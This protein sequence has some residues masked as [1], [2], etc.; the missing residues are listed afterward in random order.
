MF[1]SGTFKA[2]FGSDRVGAL[3]DAARAE[4]VMTISLNGRIATA[5]RRFSSSASGEAA[6]FAGGSGC[7]VAVID[8]EGRIVSD[9]PSFRSLFL[10]GN[11][12]RSL[13]DVFLPEERSRIDDALKSSQVDSIEVRARRRSDGDIGTFELTFDRRANGRISVLM[14]DRTQHVEELA[15]LRRE[16]ARARAE[17]REGVRALGDL[18]HEM[19]TPLNAVIGFADAMTQETFGPLGHEKYEEYAEHI[20]ASG[21]HLLDLV[22]AILDL[23]RIEADR[24]TLS[25]AM[26]E[27]G[28]IAL[29]CAEMLRLSAEKAG[30]R[31][32]TRIEPNLPACWMDARA[33]RQILINLLGNAIKFTSDGEITL[34]VGRDE[35][36]IVFAVSDNGVG[37]S[38]AELEQIGARFTSAQ[39]AGVRGAGGAGLGLS[40]AQALSELHGG[41]LSLKSAPGEGLQAEV[42]LPISAEAAPARESRGASAIGTNS[43][44][45]ALL[46]G[47]QLATGDAAFNS[48]GD[49][50]TQLERVEAYRRDAAA[51][52]KDRRASA[53]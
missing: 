42:R 37:M 38:E 29:S 34:T 1:H 27:P 51:R 3:P 40:L 21:R 14:V 33:L 18:S 9:A 6:G 36:V 7:A 17:A 4:A 48:S 39:I 44:A 15:Q 32:T 30:L 52:R 16:A 11:D 49:V 47:A 35:D 43:L 41:S 31:L 10:R 46:D 28:K 50:L 53:A 2:K 5:L 25:R 22:S 8:G 23:A 45:P 19:R 13:L 24:F 20:R 26:V 12:A